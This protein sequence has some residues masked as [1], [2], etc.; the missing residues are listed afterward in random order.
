MSNSRF[1][2]YEDNGCSWHSR[3]LECPELVCRFDKPRVRQNK[4]GEYRKQQIVDL[5]SAGISPIKVANQ[6]NLSKRT[7]F[8]YLEKERVVTK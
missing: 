5:I 3:C 2:E 6:F 8:R 1:V 7:I 4:I